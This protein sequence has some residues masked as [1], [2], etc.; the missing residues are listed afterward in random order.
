MWVISE[1][2]QQNTPIDKSFFFFFQAEDGIRDDLVTGVQTCALPIFQ[3][4]KPLQKFPKQKKRRI[5]NGKHGNVYNTRRSDSRICRD[6]RYD[7]ANNES[8]HIP[9]VC[10]LW[11]SRSIFPA[12]L[13]VP[14]RSSDFYLR[15]RYHDDIYL[16][17]PTGK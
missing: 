16:R 14:G 2:K 3:R 10:S 17:Y 6:V 1:S 11:S 13:Y 9:V 5:N 12:R 7:E 15:R 8:S 4:L